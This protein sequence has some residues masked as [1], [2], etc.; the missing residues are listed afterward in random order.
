MSDRVITFNH[1]LSV[2]VKQPYEE[3]H[4]LTALE[5]E[6]L[7]HLLA[8]NIRTS[9]NA[10]LKNLSKDKPEDWAPEPPVA[11][12]FQAFADSYAFSVKRERGP[13]TDP[14]TREA[15]KIAKEKIFMAIRA[16]G[17]APQNYKADEIAA[18]VG[19]VMASPKGEEIRE[20]AARR[21][22]ASRKIASDTL[23]DIFADAAE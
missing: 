18:L 23:E 20:E 11:T 22:E 16:K 10:K 21:I 1:G 8:D 13:S 5:A 9:L 12:E 14:I 19:K 2:S 15:H 3:G 4:V 6:K 17:G 7:N